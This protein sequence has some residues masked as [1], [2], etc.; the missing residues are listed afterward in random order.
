M[1]R[2]EDTGS[3]SMEDDRNDRG[4]GQGLVLEEVLPE[5]V[6]RALILVSTAAVLLFSIYCLSH[7]ITIIFMHL[8]YFPIVLLAYRYR[9]RG[10]V[11]ATL[12]ALAYVGLVVFFHPEQT[13]VTGAFY[14]FAVFIGIA[15]VVAYLSERLA[16]AHISQ[17]EGLGTIQNLQQFQES[18]ITN[19]NVWITVLAPDGT[20]LVWNDAAEAISGYKRGDVLGMKTVWKNLYP[21]KVY[22]QKVTREIQR[23]I[24]RDTY[25][26]NFETEILCA[27]GTQKTIVWNTRGIHDPT[28]TILSY[29]AIGRDITE[30]KRAEKALRE[31]ETLL[32]EV[33]EMAHVGGWELDVGTKA[34]HWTTETYRIHDISEDEKF[35]L[36]KAVLF[37]DLP[38]RSILEGA[39]QRCMETGEPFDL[40]I[41]FTSA[42]GRHLW[43]R[44]IGR[45]VSVGGQVV[46]I[47]GAFQ[48]ITERRQ[49][50][51]AL[52][53]SKTLIDAVVENVPLMIFLK[54]AT[55]LRFVIFNRAGE[56]LLGYDRQALLGKNNLDLFPPD[57]AAQFM[58]KDREVLDGD[59]GMLDIPEEPITTAK[60]GLRLLHTRKVC[61]RG[62]DGTTKFLLGISEDITERK[63]AEDALR[64]SNEYLHMLIDFANAPIIVW[65]PEFRITRFNHAFE[66]LTGRVEHEVIEQPLDILFPK[67]SRDNSLILIKKTLKGE[68]WETVEIPILTKEG[69]VR[70]VLWNSA[71]ILDSDGRIISTIAQGVDITDRKRVEEAL[72]K[73]QIQLAEA[74]D[75]AH[76]VNWEFDVATGIFTF[77]DRFYALYGTT[78]EQEG[79]NKIPVEVY[80]RKFVHPDDQYMVANEVNKAI[81]AT[82][83]G[84]VSQVEHRIIRRDGEIRHIVVRFGITKDANGRTIKTHG[85]NQDITERNRAEE[86]IRESEERY[87]T[88]AE[89]SPDQIFIVGRDDTMKYV[90]TAAQKM[91]G[92]P[93]DKVVGTPRKNLFPPAIAD[94][95]GILLKK[96]F[97]TGESIKTEEK[98]QFGTQE[99]WV[100]T[101]FVP[102]KDKTGN[103]TAVLGI[104]HDITERKKAEMLL[105]QFNEELEQQVKSRTKD[106]DV[107][108]KEKEGLL[109]EIHHRVRNNLQVVSSIISLQA[110]S[111]GDPA[112][113]QQIQEIRMRIGTLALVHE[114][115]YLAK[116]P[117]SI[118]MRDFLHRCTSRV[119]DEFKC[120]PGR[121]NITITAENVQVALSQAVPC[122]LI[123]NELLMNSIRHAFPGNRRGE[124]R[125]GFSITKGNYVLEYDD[126]G[127]GLP[128]GLHPLQAETGGLALIHGLARQIRGTVKSRTHPGTGY[129][130]TFPAEIGG[131]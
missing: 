2:R 10:F 113:L 39:L 48:D 23:V 67:E 76:L 107:S 90:N 71:N 58:I 3:I 112:S 16:A 40:E 37:F 104:A 57:Q 123:V 75:L 117:E 101:S 47:E 12:L 80:A 63:R 88:L 77:D 79:G 84:F 1:N 87:R 8:Y 19:A 115:A 128:E 98:I 49:A 46:K 103:V 59:A 17:K 56:E 96:I 11:H 44:A 52:R 60:K 89:A 111:V 33:G 27:D 18:V 65:D 69:S 91:F 31:R 26:E 38:G 36:S 29:I 62:G 78:A 92:L 127:V 106:L 116:T 74:M 21:D 125:I 131:T 122:S 119:I 4:T 30:Q 45:A 105:N 126:D 83:P 82:D 129:T 110:K 100:D 51:D 50:E 35:D 20:I 97:E 53:E 15:A 6:W 94:A 61:I 5:N 73:S 93:Y 130:L 54:E 66:S 95:Q 43:T 7:G 24:G 99:F 9:Y 102:L 41:P 28:G 81:Q 86:A 55:D 114:I 42:K 22:R 120:E 72:K 13:E 25:L 70:T 34:V 109:K 32:N 121:I 85:A 108:L 64:E 124:I 118:N 68:H 14:R